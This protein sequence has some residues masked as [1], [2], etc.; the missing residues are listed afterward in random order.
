MDEKLY[1]QR[2]I[3]CPKVGG[4]DYQVKRG[5]EID[6]GKIK[7]HPKGERLLKRLHTYGWVGNSPPAPLK[8]EKATPAKDVKKRTPEEL[9]AQENINR[10]PKPQPR[11]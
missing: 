9:D 6:V 1:A 10:R 7:L 5:E 11:G 3:R 2:N 4:G 8:S